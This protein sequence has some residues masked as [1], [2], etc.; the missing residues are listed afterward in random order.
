MQ[1]VAALQ[2]WGGRRDGFD[3]V[4]ALIQPVS[5]SVAYLGYFQVFEGD[6]QNPGIDETANFMLPRAQGIEPGSNHLQWYYVRHLR[7]S[8][9]Y[10]WFPMQH[11]LGEVNA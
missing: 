1:Y 11:L 4:V 7:C 10:S 9:C 5:N 8:L 3:L 2:R 6:F